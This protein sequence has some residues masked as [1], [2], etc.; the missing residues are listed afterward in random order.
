MRPL[1]SI[2]KCVVCGK[3]YVVVSGRQKYCSEICQRKGVLE[4]QREHKKNYHKVSGQ[5]I[6]KQARRN[7][8]KKICVYCLKSFESST[9]TN[10]CSEYCR[11][12]QKNYY[13]A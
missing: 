2:D 8:V 6:K 7:T 5:N 11:T 9:P 1:G 13:S 3:D 4:W 12:E 10:L